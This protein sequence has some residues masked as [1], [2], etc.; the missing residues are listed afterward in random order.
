MRYLLGLILLCVF[1]VPPA[2]ARM[3]KWVDDKGDVHYGDT[4]PPQFSSQAASELNQR[5]IVVKKPGAALTSEQIK[6]REAARKQAK[7]QARRDRALLA[8]Y[9]NEQEIDRARDRRLRQIQ[10]RIG[11]LTAGRATAQKRLTSNRQR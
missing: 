11:G 2:M 3:Y 8:T 6:A 7:A 4:I 9:V 5:G 1:L 10:Q